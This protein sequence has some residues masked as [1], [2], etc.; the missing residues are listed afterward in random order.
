MFFSWLVAIFS[1]WWVFRSH[2]TMSPLSWPVTMNSSRVPH[3]MEVT[4]GPLEGMV[5][6]IR[7]SELK[8]RMSTTEMMQ[9]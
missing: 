3:S 1:L 6:C 4:L 7:G 9:G 2:W 5:I 8:L